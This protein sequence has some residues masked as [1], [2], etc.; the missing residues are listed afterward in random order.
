[1]CTVS[2]GG[3][4]NQSNTT[5]WYK[6]VMLDEN[7]I[8]SYSLKILSCVLCVIKSLSLIESMRKREILGDLVV[9]RRSKPFGLSVHQSFSSIA[10]GRLPI[11]SGV[12]G[13]VFEFTAIAGSYQENGVHQEHDRRDDRKEARCAQQ[14][15]PKSNRTIKSS[16]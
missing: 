7:R 10:L 8:P 15:Q 2:T 4:I 16:N 1:M 9:A 6:E 13:L 14:I 5:I 11:G 3:Y 12:A